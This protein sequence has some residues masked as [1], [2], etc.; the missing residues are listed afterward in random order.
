MLVPAFS[1]RLTCPRPVRFQLALSERP[2]LMAE[3]S[4]LGSCGC[5][6]CNTLLQVRAHLATHLGVPRDPE[7][8]CRFTCHLQQVCCRLQ[9]D[10]ELKGVGRLLD[11]SLR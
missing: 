11:A 2:D 8:D 3:I 6:T 7:G 10:V 1:R 5:R 9:S 4:T